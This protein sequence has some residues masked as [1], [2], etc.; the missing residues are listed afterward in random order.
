MLAVVKTP[1][2]KIEIKGIIPKKLLNV[3]KEE[4]GSEVQL[5][6]QEEDEKINVFETDWYKSTK[7]KLTP[8]KNLRIYRQ[9]NGMTQQG[10]GELLGGIPRQHISN[11][12]KGT[13]AISK[14]VA[15]KLSK[16]FNTSVE[17]FIG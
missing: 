12:E 10:L 4:Y 3:L 5:V 13:R 11:M 8:G 6:P 15:L 16:F 2:I 9:N 7:E 1:L 17:K 14:K